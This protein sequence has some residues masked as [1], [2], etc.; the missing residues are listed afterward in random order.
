[1]DS[2]DNLLYWSFTNNQLTE[3]PAFVYNLK[4]ESGVYLGN[5]LITT[6]DYK[7][8]KI[9][10]SEFYLHGNPMQPLPDSVNAWLRKMDPLWTN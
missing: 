10:L 7:V 4:K 2:V 5:N 3:V 8:M 1:M 6:F 9:G